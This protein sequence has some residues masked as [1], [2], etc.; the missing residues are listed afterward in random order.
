MKRD[1]FAKDR[2]EI[3]ELRINGESRLNGVALSNLDSIIKCKV[4]V[5]AVLRKGQAIMPDGNFIF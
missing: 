1:S 5:C 2:V 3:V 4:L